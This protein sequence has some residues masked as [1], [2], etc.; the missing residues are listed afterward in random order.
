VEEPEGG[1]REK[2]WPVPLRATDCG[3]PGALSLKETL[4]D[5]A[6]PAVGVKVIAT[7]QVPL[8]ATGFAV[9]HVVPEAATANG[10]LTAGALLKLRLAVPVLVRVMVCELLVPPTV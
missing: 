6:P 5:A 10:P 2:S 1:A 3:L 4:P 7:V 9:K 8:A